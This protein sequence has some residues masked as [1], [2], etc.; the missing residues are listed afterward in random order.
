MPSA[1]G[2]QAWKMSVDLNKSIDFC[3]WT[4]LKDG[5]RVEPFDSHRDGT[6]VLS[7]AG[8]TESGWRKWLE[9]VVAEQRAKT[10][11]MEAD[12]HETAKWKKWQDAPDLWTGDP[13]IGWAL[14]DLWEAFG[15]LAEKSRTESSEKVDEL[16]AGKNLR[17]VLKPYQARLTGLRAYAVHYPKPVVLIFKP[18]TALV[19]LGKFD[20]WDFERQMLQAA[21]ALATA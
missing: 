14:S 21:E 17:R 11:S 10:R 19:G 18:D 13:V 2:D 12:A 6:R 7:G 5:L 1:K 16:M 15:V 9:A 20:P 3:V 8:L 4:L